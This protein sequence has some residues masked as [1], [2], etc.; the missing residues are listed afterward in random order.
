MASTALCTTGGTQVGSPVALAASAPPPG[1]ASATSAAVNTAANPSL[2][3]RYC[4]RADWPGDTN[5]TGGPFTH[6]GTG[7][8]ECFIVRQI[9]TTTVTTPSDGSGVALVGPVAL[10][11]TLYDK[12]VVTGTAAGGNPPGTVDFFLCN[13]TQTTGAA[14]AEVCATGGTNLS[15]NPRTLVA[16]AGSSPPSSSVLSS[17]GVAANMAGVWCFRAVYTP[18]GSTYTGSSDARHSECIEVSEAPTTTVTTP[19]VGSTAITNPVAVGTDVT[20]YALVT[21]SAADGTPTGTINFFICDPTE[22]TGT[23]GN[24]V[25][26]T[27]GDSAGSKTAAAVARIEPAKVRCNLRSG[28]HRGRRRL[29]LPRRVRAGRRQWRRLHGFERLQP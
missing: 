4:F 15:G 21:G 19:R 5:Y 14:G 11:T 27:G 28:G 16:D 8:S 29:V 3:G 1:E 22:T 12:A 26:A 25:C 7:N 13:P 6:A 10:G 20:D 2:P 23:A 18:S 9:A 17:P 24:E